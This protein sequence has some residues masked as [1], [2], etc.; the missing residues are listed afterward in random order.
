MEVVTIIRVVAG[1]LFG[2][3]LVTLIQRRRIRV[4]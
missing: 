3:V 4:K 1:V 2:V